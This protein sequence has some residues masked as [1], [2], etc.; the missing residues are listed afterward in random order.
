MHIDLAPLE[1]KERYKLIAGAI[2]PRPIALVTSLNADGSVNAAPFSAFNYMSED[3]PLVA[4]GIQVHPDASHRRGERKDTARNIADRGTFVINLVDEPMLQ[5][6]VDCAVDF[7]E[8]DSEIERLGLSLEPIRDWP[9]PRVA[10]APVAMACR[11][12]V[13]LDFGSF[14]SVLIAEIASMWFRDD[15]I[16]PATG[17][18]ALERYAPIGRLTGSSYCRTK[19]RLAVPTIDY[20]AWLARRTAETTEVE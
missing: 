3:P 9:V 8:G 14:R 19:D 5:A 18:V 15:L 16:D 4:L 12:V 1:R 17:R 7:P 13:M 20:A 11:R 2:V 6:M 10:A